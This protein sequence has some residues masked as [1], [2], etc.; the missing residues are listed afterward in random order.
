MTWMELKKI[1][2]ITLG[3]DA[4]KW[5]AIVKYMEQ[6]GIP[7]RATIGVAMRSQSCLRCKLDRPPR[8]RRSSKHLVEKQGSQLA[9]A[10]LLVFSEKSHMNLPI[11]HEGQHEQHN[12]F[13][14]MQR[15]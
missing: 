11:D 8:R 9:L 15:E 7:C 6:R 10:S 3:N 5:C 14:R 12:N 13:Y 2:T 4:K 1:R